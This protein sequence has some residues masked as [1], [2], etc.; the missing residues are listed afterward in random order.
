M[1]RLLEAMGVAT[2]FI[3]QIV[4]FVGICVG[5]GFVFQHYG[6]IAV[7]CFCIVLLLVVFIVITIDYYNWK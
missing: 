2:L 3:F 5:L 7:A 6:G 4:L 1:K